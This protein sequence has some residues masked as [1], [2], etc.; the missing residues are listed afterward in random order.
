MLTRSL[1]EWRWHLQATSPT[2]LIRSGREAQ[3]VRKICEL[4]LA[5]HLAAAA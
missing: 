2:G 5:G 3:S 1:S 4:G